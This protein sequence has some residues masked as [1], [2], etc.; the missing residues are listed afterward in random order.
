MQGALRATSLIGFA[1]FA[2]LL[3]EGNSAHAQQSGVTVQLPTFSYFSVNTSVLVPD[4]GAGFAAAMRRAEANRI[5]T[6]GKQDSTSVS[7]ASI[8]GVAIHSTIHD[9]DSE[10][11]LALQN[12]P[13]QGLGNSLFSRKLEA[14]QVSSAGRAELS[15][16]EIERNRSQ[17]DKQQELEALQLLKRGLAAESKGRL[18][19]AAIYYRQAAS[20]ASGDLKATAIER[21]KAVESERTSTSDPS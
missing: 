7:G 14:A 20:R 8:G 18:P 15:V 6:G 21:L 17:A 16:A 9:R 2:W 5:A 12:A 19:V 4:S 3:L 11:G 1:V 10:P 13:Q